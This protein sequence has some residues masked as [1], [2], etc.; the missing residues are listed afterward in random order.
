MCFAMPAFEGWMVKEGGK[1]KTWRK[2]W[3]QL[4][5]DTLYYFSKPPVFGEEVEMKGMVG[6]NNANLHEYDDKSHPNTF[7]ISC[8]YNSQGAY[9]AQAKFD[10]TNH[11]QYKFSCDTAQEKVAW[12]G[13]LHRSIAGTIPAPPVYAAPSSAS[14]SAAPTRYR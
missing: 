7:L 13:A 1:R 5:G 8:M 3:F 11:S 9:G 4:V 2:R 6:L 10:D 12:M 14:Q